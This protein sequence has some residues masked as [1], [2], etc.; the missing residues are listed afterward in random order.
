MQNIQVFQIDCKVYLM[1]DVALK[2][3]LEEICSF[4]DL[5]LG[6]DEKMSKFH[7][8]RGYKNYVHSG[9]KELELEKTY[10]EGK[11][12]SFSIRC[13]G[14]ELKNYFS[15][16]LS[17]INTSTMKGLVTTVKLIPKV[18]IEKLYTL[19]PALIKLEEGY[20]KGNI[21]FAKYEKR[22]LE[23]SIKKAKLILGE[24]FSEDFVLYN[25]I[26]ILNQKPI[27]NCFKNIMFLGD[28]FE[29]TISDNKMA[30]QIAYILLGTGVCEMNA[31]GYGYVNYKSGY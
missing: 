3:V 16:V 20:W 30:Q 15:M 7:E 29:L 4:I 6:Q 21:S 12:Y 28:K 9:F 26:E 25:S 27:A 1:R 8:G 17:D 2:N 11:I 23:N 24:D 5:G 18:Y 22:L 19:T 13:V 10:K 14:D 31:R